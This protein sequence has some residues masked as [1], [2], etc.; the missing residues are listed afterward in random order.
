MLENNE[1]LKELKEILKK[2]E[3]NERHLKEANKAIDKTLDKLN[4]QEI[5]ITEYYKEKLEE[6][7]NDEK[8]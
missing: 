7:I 5:G 3:D 1:K 4:K 2:K 8:T 6:S